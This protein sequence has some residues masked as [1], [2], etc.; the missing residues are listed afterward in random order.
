MTREETHRAP[1]RLLLAL[2]CAAAVANVYYAQPLL[3]RIGGDLGIATSDLGWVVTLSQAGYLAGL[4][5]LVPLGD[6]MSRRGL[7]TLQLLAT[8]VGTTVAG[9][10]SSAFALFVG[11][12]VAGLF[13]VVVQVTV[14]FAA[15]L[16]DPAERGRTIGVVT[17]GVVTGIILARTV[18]GAL[19]DVAGWHAVY[20]GSAVACAGLAIVAAMRLPHDARRPGAHR[21][22]S[23]LI[24]LASV[25]LLAAGNRIFR[26]RAAMTLFL[27][28]SFGVLWSGIALPLGA[29]PWNLSTTTIG[30]FGVAGLAGAL[31][32][33]RAGRW[34]DRGHGDTVTVAALMLLIASWA[35]IGR[36]GDSLLLLAV[37]VVALDFAVQAVHVTSQDRIVAT[38]PD[39]GSRL[40][41]G[42]MVFYSLGSGLGAITTTALYDRAG[43]TAVSLAGAGYAVLALAV[44]GIDRIWRAAEHARPA[45]CPAIATCDHRGG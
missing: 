41:G 45:P 12:T 8:A 42:Y 29:P 20:L 14:A 7:I 4:V 1:P 9:T 24:A 39:A 38:R 31:A 16:A 18:S 30:L 36:L 25:P 32:A 40:I 44:L 34:A 33:A 6:L 2:L 26:V 23:Y 22:R 21:M 19:A 13:S 27:F 28:A 5:I 17:S 43:W 15:D 37:G 10:A 35:A 11:V 3:G